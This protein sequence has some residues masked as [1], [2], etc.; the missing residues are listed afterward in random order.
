[1][2]HGD[3][4]Q[5][6]QEPAA[7]PCL[8]PDQSIPCPPSRFLKITFNIIL[9]LYLGLPSGL[10]SSSFPKKTLYATHPMRATCRAN[11]LDFLTRIIFGER[12]IPNIQFVSVPL[13]S[14]LSQAYRPVSFSFSNTFSLSSSLRMTDQVSHE[15][16]VEIRTPTHRNL[17]SFSMTVHRL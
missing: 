16:P 5:D 10:F 15:S 8:Q 11:L 13:L 12:Y 14:H 7:S 1:M 4:L 6:S 9:H 17:N 2:E 3:L